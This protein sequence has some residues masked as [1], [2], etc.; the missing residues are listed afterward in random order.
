VKRHIH[1]LLI[2]LINLV[3]VAPLAAQNVTSHTFFSVRPPA[4][5]ASPEVVAFTHDQLCHS[6]LELI[7]FGGKTVCGKNANNL[8]QFFFPFGKCSL[9]AGEFGSEAVQ[10]NSADLIASY[11]GVET[12]DPLLSTSDEYD[13]TAGIFESRIAI[14]PEQSVVGCDIRL[15]QRITG[16]AHERGWWVGFNMPIVHVTNYLNFTEQIINPGSGDIQPGFVGTMTSAL[17]GDTVFGDKHFEFARVP[18]GCSL[19]KT[20]IA[21]LELNVGYFAICGDTCHLESYVGLIIPTGNKP[22][23]KYIFEPIVGNNHHWAISFGS[24]YGFELW[25][26]DSFTVD[27]ECATDSRFL[28]SNTQCRSL[29]LVDKQWSRYM[30]L[31]PN[32]QAISLADITPGI[33]FLTRSMRVEPRLVFTH[34]SALVAFGDYWKAEVGYN[35]YVRQAERVCLC[36]FTEGPGIVGIDPEDTTV[37]HTKNNATMRQYGITPAQFIGVDIDPNFVPIKAADLNLQSAAHPFTMTQTAYAAIGYRWSN[38]RHE[39]SLSIGG[40]YE[41]TEDNSGLEQWKVWGKGSVVW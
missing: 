21:D 39:P 36:G 20:G 9:L 35:L 41:H 18:R 37:L 40:D 27:L 17:Q 26:C 33:N 25:A 23:G 10:T 38:H 28:F 4:Q 7:P 19:S 29:D 22:C 14:R 24:A 11:F 31:Y 34:N 5:T 12:A 8:A 13:F 16:T 32:D 1:S 2:V 6:G 30:W 15:H 3:I